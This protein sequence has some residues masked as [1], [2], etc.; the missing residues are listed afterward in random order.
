VSQSYFPDLPAFA[1]CVS[2]FCAV[3]GFAE[4]WVLLTAEPVGSAGDAAGVLLTEVSALP[5]DGLTFLFTNAVLVLTLVDGV[6]ERVTSLLAVGT[7]AIALTAADGVTAR[8]AVVVGVTG[9]G[10]PSASAITSRRSFRLEIGPL[11]RKPA[12]LES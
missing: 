7:D 8:E 3:P 12:P 6:V 9:T 2:C 4:S 11:S 10:L 5:M 1:E